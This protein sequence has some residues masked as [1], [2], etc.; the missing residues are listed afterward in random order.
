[1]R[2]VSARLVDEGL[3][4][5]TSATLSLAT[6]TVDGKAEELALNASMNE[7]VVVGIR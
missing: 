5:D 2:E 7:L 3:A 4:L 1:M 6:V